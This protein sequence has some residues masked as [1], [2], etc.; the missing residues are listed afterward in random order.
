MDALRLPSALEASQSILIAGAGGGFDVYTGLPLYERL[1]SLGKRVYLANLSFTYLGGTSAKALTP[2][3]HVVD[4]TTSGEDQYFPER[5]LAS[6]LSSRSGENVTVYAFDRMGVAAVREGYRY[7][8]QSLKL[9]AI[10]LT[11]GGTDILMRGDEAGLGT[12]AEDMMS[13]AAVAALDVPARMVAC[14][15]FGIDAYHGICHANWLENVSGLIEAGGFLGAIALRKEM[16]EVQSYIDAVNAADQATPGRGSI[17]NGS[18]VSALE[19]RFGDYHR[20]ER[21]RSSRLFISP[22]MNFIWMF[23][24]AAVACR[25]LYLDRIEQTRTIW[26]VLS[27]IESFRNEV[28][29]RQVQSIPY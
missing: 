11:D 18:I 22:L 7:L 12:P 6:F 26:D 16:P 28:R 25:N 29:S 23:D 21:T 17:V 10:V 27:A 5:S 24:L 15:G 14:V 9:D 13:L 3:L 4:R 19:G 1:R 20:T 8:V 2:A